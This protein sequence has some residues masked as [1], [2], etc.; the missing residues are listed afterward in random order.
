M[1]IEL[2]PIAFVHNERDTPEDDDWLRVPSRIELAEG[3]PTEALD[4]IEGF[5]HLEI[6]FFMNQV[7]A[8]KAVARARHPRNDPSLP[9]V[10]TYAQRNKSRPNRLGLT[11][12]EL[13]RREGRILEVRR[14]DAIDGTPI[15]DIKP[16]MAE[17]EP[18]S[19]IR[20]PE[21]TRAIMANYWAKK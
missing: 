3:I 15:L 14:F 18:A 11:T 1:T 6:L 7:P 19:P 4:G 21:W 8:E 5:S 10:G 13:L 20:Q 9:R 2:D 12:V 17:F 16:V